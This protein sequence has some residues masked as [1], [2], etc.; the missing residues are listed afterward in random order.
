MTE[1]L[2]LEGK[3]LRG[4]DGSRLI[5]LRIRE[6]LLSQVDDL[7]QKTGKSRNEIFSVLVSYA[8]SNCEVKES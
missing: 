8:L 4:E 1:K 3:H 5:S 7:A 6:T 2:I